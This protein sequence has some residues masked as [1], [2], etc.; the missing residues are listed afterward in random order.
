ML[1]G[2]AA[3]FRA[4]IA[5]LFDQMAGPLAGAE[6]TRIDH[7]RAAEQEVVLGIWDLLLTASVAELDAVVDSLAGAITV[8]YLSLHGIDPGPDYGAWLTDRIAIASVEV[9]PGLGHYPHLIEP[10]RFVE[11]VAAFDRG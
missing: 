10:A 7:L 2:S 4:A 3:E 5:A 8:P 6:R 11:R 9:W 1:R